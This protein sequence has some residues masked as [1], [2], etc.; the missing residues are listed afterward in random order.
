MN[1][2][3]LQ[4]LIKEIENEKLRDYLLNCLKNECE[5]NF[6]NTPSVLL[7]KVTQRFENK[8]KICQKIENNL[9]NH[10]ISHGDAFLLTRKL[11]TL[12]L[13]LA[14]LYTNQIYEL[15]EDDYNEIK[16]FIFKILNF[17]NIHL[18]LKIFDLTIKLLQ[19][20]TEFLKFNKD[21]ISIL[22]LL[23]LLINDPHAFKLEHLQNINTLSEKDIK[24]DFYGIVY[25]F[26]KKLVFQDLSNQLALIIRSCDQSLLMQFNLKFITNCIQ[27][28]TMDTD[29]FTQLL[30]LVFRSLKCYEFVSKNGFSSIR[31]NILRPKNLT[32]YL[33][34]FEKEFKEKIPK[35]KLEF[36]NALPNL[37]TDKPQESD[38][39]IYFPDQI[40]NEKLIVKFNET[41]SQIFNEKT[42]SND[43]FSLNFWKRAGAL[44]NRLSGFKTNAKVLA[45]KATENLKVFVGT[46]TERLKEFII[47]KT[48]NF[49]LNEN[50]E[51]TENELYLNDSLINAKA[52]LSSIKKNWIHGYQ[53]LIISLNNPKLKLIL[54]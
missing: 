42:E 43:H 2:E 6:L 51:I 40:K 15:T 50:A 13:N 9:P 25:E 22:D 1:V 29:D 47:K 44:S 37:V 36:E 32:E 35:V 4:Y 46:N 24:K 38:I 30:T 28:Q 20:T 19:K 49:D 41:K 52:E 17:P 48:E 54:L 27:D 33:L 39:S 34:K 5:L 16:T 3:K 7:E 31:N 21:F 11:D 45:T 26:N 14:I 53:N 18:K 8:I 10:L 23:K 12:K